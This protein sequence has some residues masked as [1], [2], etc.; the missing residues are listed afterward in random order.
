M[1]PSRTANIRF[2][3]CRLNGCLWVR[4]TSDA[5]RARRAA[6]AT[7]RV[8]LLICSLLSCV[9]VFVGC[10]LD[11]FGTGQVCPR[12]ALFAMVDGVAAVG[13]SKIL[14]PA[15]PAYP[16]WRLVLAMEYANDCL[17]IL[18]D[19]MLTVPN[20][21]VEG[22][23]VLVV[24]TRDSINSGAP[25]PSQI[26]QLVD[27]TSRFVVSPRFVHIRRAGGID[28]FPLF[29]G[30]VSLNATST[31]WSIQSSSVEPLMHLDADYLYTGFDQG[32]IYLF[33]YK[34]QCDG[35]IAGAVPSPR[36]QAVL[37][38]GQLQFITAPTYGKTNG[39]PG[40]T[41]GLTTD[42]NFIYVSNSVSILTYPITR[43][44]TQKVCFAAGTPT[45]ATAGTSITLAATAVTDTPAISVIA[46]SAAVCALT[47]SILQFL[48]TG[49]CTVEAAVAA[50]GAYLDSQAS[51]T[52]IVNPNTSQSMST[53]AW[54]C[55]RLCMRLTSS[56]RSRVVC[57][58][59]VSHSVWLPRCGCGRSCLSGV[60]HEPVWRPCVL[61]SPVVSGLHQRGVEQH[62]LAQIQVDLRLRTS[63][64]VRGGGRRRCI[65]GNED[66]TD[67]AMGAP[68]TGTFGQS[69]RGEVHTHAALRLRIA[70]TMAVF[71]AVRALCAAQ[72]NPLPSI[73]YVPRPPL[74]LTATFTPNFPSQVRYAAVGEPAGVCWMNDTQPANLMFGNVIG[75]AHMHEAVADRDARSGQRFLMC[76]CRCCLC[77]SALAP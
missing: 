19:V 18:M 5:T 14:T 49:V 43:P 55:C 27:R 22:P 26:V 34:V 60:G 65:R 36:A 25:T 45:S 28:S 16:A 39:W 69:R 72:F 29:A 52:I 59:C 32:T 15:G 66:A 56:S 74:T 2:S 57:R 47:D 70:L 12:V 64:A 37:N 63:R 67:R 3:P 40:G 42:A 73:A 17:F 10:S 21:P 51:V 76:V 20:T 48:A 7:S 77:V 58:G 6:L 31:L 50:T 71:V 13:A 30:T 8:R 68:T 44:K 61:E 75:S 9:V 41:E 35:T 54:P 1:Q 24:Y 4:G 62:Q 46:A 23:S 38:D 11:P 33:V 53:P